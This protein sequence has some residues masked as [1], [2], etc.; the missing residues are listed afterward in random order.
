MG[1]LVD[2]DRV[3]SL[4]GLNHKDYEYISKHELAKKIEN[5]PTVE[6]G[7]TYRFGGTVYRVV[8]DTVDRDMAVRVR[9]F[10]DDF[11][12]PKVGRWEYRYV[13]DGGMFSKQRFY[14][15]ECGKWQTY[16]K[17]E[18]CPR[19]GAKMEDE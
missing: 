13:E 12:E 1:N 9:K 3:I 10:V 8:F 14:C 19:C 17:T 15:S 4:L 16:G 6:D 11:K 18:Y 5:L 2:R 7:E